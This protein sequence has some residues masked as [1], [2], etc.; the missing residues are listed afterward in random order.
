MAAKPGAQ[1]FADPHIAAVLRRGGLIGLTDNPELVPLTGGVSSAIWRVALNDQEI[2]VKRAHDRLQVAAEWHAPVERNKFEARYYATLQ[3]IASGL[4]PRLIYVDRPYN[5]LVME[6]LPPERFSLWK[7]ALMTGQ[8]DRPAAAAVGAALGAIHAATALSAQIAS[9]FDSHRIFSDIRLEPYLLAMIQ[10]HPDLGRP[11]KQLAERTFSTRRV[12]VHGDVSPKNILLDGTRPVFLDAEC[13]VY[14]DPAFDLAFCLNHL[15]LKR[16]VLPDRGA[17][18]MAAFDRLVDAYL[19]RV[20]WEPRLAVEAR[21]ASL[22]PA[23]TLARIDGKSPVEY[24]DDEA[25][26]LH[27]RETV[28]PMISTPPPSLRSVAA[29]WHEAM[30]HV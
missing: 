23:L 16:A 10:T 11:L 28:R 30:D 17:D 19:A 22:L 6:F 2:C 26:R 24:I 29:A 12:L 14:G 4:A 8:V 25:L 20:T 7:A 5:T 15:L 9:D 18:L 27:I 21:T 3:R 1:N 13:A